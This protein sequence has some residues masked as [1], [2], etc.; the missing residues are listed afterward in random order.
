MRKL[1]VICCDYAMN[2]NIEVIT[3]YNEN[4]PLFDQLQNILGSYIK[5]ENL[6]NEIYVNRIINY[7]I[8]EV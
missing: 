2:E 6:M 8:V 7:S 5:G 1:K 4:I 3:S